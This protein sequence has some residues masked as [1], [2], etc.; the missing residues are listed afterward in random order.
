MPW[1]QRN[2]HKKVRFLFIYILKMFEISSM[3]ILVWWC[4]IFVWLHEWMSMCVL[5]NC[6]KTKYILLFI[7]TFGISYD[8]NSTKLLGFL[9]LIQ[10]NWIYH[11]TRTYTNGFCLIVICYIRHFSS[12][13]L[14]LIIY[15]LYNFIV[16][17]INNI[18]KK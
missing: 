17:W 2:S 8:L 18:I 11:K 3:Y 5:T 16:S 4:S 1:F 10:N 12:T 9:I 14:I 7:W 15:N 13:N 6:D